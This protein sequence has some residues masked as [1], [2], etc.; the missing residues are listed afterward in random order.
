MRYIPGFKSLVAACVLVLGST[1][2][3]STDSGNAPSSTNGG[4]GDP[5]Q[6]GG[7]ST[8]NGKPAN[9]YFAQFYFETLNSDMH[10]TGSMPANSAGHDKFIVDLFLMKNG[11]FTL[12]YVEGTSI[13]SGVKYST[14]DGRKVTGSWSVEGS[15]LKAGPLDCD[16]LSLNGEDVLSC[17]VTTAIVSTT[18]VGKGATLSRGFAGEDP[19]SSDFADY[20]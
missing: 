11:S 14:S 8:I 18:A 6:G 9:E 16:G 17:E 7:S 2:C 13:D 3:S 10:G 12:Y 1:A 15:T 5:S 19:N 20:K 4:S